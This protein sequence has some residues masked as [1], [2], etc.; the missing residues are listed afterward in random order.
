MSC[1]NTINLMYHWQL[2]IAITYLWYLHNLSTDK[3]Q[4]PRLTPWYRSTANSK[5]HQ[6][7]PLLNSIHLIKVL[8][9]SRQRHSL[10]V[11]S[12]YGHGQLLIG[13]AFVCETL[14]EVWILEMHTTLPR[15]CAKKSCLAYQGFRILMH[16]TSLWLA[17]ILT[18]GRAMIAQPYY[19]S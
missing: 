10:T 4:V 13:S 17:F 2:W 11:Y 19:L 5:A 3:G 18:C 14:N 6:G 12:A 7:Q 16:T 15:E 8:N 9:P 1:W